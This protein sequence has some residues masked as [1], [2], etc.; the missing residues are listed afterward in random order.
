M[1]YLEIARKKIREMEARKDEA[2]QEPIPPANEDAK[3][4]RIEVA[5]EEIDRFFNSQ[6]LPEL[7]ALSRAGRLSDLEDDPAWTEATKLWNT[8]ARDSKA[9]AEAEEIKRALRASVAKY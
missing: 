9:P 8:L 4:V 5:R 6:I 7:S 2:K 3:R 1:G